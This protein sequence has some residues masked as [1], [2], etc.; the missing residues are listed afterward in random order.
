MITAI[1]AITTAEGTVTRWRLSPR[2][3]AMIISSRAS[4]A[5]L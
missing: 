5:S 1:G 4:P 3:A 2:S